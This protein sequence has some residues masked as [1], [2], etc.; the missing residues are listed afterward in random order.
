[1][2]GG[3]LTLQVARDLYTDAYNPKEPKP[4]EHISDTIMRKP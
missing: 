1:M 4:W 2:N 3:D